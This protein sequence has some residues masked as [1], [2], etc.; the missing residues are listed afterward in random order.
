VSTSLPEWMAMRKLT[1]A[2]LRAHFGF[3]ENYLDRNTAYGQ[4]TNLIEF[5]N[6]DKH[7]GRF[8]F[9]AHDQTT[10]VVMYVG[11][12]EALRSLARDDLIREFGVPEARLRSRAGKVYTHYVCPRSGVA[13]SSSKEDVAFIE[14]FPEM[15]LKNYRATLYLDPGDFVK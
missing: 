10:L 2:E 1:L 13:F 15:T 3:S 11:S 6:P 9:D 7:P 8:F 5:H 14:T 12:S 4:L